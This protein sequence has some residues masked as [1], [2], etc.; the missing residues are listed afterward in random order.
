MASQENHPHGAA[1]I[2]T[3]TLTIQFDSITP[4][5]GYDFVD[6]H[7]SDKDFSI[8]AASD[9]I[10]SSS[11]DPKAASAGSPTVR[12]ASATEEIEPKSLEALDTESSQNTSG[13][14]VEK[15]KELSKSLQGT[16]LQERRM[17]H[18]AFEPVSLPASRVCLLS[19]CLSVAGR[20]ESRKW[21]YSNNDDS[22]LK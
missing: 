16:H 11:L 4:W 15:L 19:L 18:F 22:K 20:P 7:I 1:P 14:D 13:Q 6:N 3:S 12:F 10:T 5:P 17:S 2:G 8:I 21:K 9:H